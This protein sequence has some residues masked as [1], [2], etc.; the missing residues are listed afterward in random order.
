MTETG[1]G[2]VPGTVVA[3]CGPTGSGKTAV[4]IALAERLRAKG[5]DAAAINCDAMQIYRGLPLLTNQPSTA[6]QKALEHRLVGFA[7]PR[8]E[9]SAGRYAEL[10]HQEIDGVLTD[11]KIPIVVGG[12]GLY[13][14]AALCELEMR[15]PVP[16]EVRAE[17]ERDLATEGPAALHALLPESRRARIHPNDRK[18]VART[19]ELLRAGLEPSPDSAGLWTERTRH[20]TRIFGLTLRRETLVTRIEQRTDAM[21]AAGVASE[22]RAIEETGPARTVRTAHG[23]RELLEERIDDWRRAQREYARRQLTWMRKT[24]GLVLI[25]R[26]GLGDDQVAERIDA[27]LR[28]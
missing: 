23:Y 12:T 28:A 4:A 24:P 14:R 17:V 6:E 9:F 1:P 22:V 13:M 18:R 25:E 19:T 2:A 7:D 11:G 3:I 27:T 26:D 15:P 21:L 5:G 16:P 10:A 8:E 20:P